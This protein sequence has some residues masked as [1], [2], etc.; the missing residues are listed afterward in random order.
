MDLRCPQ[1]GSP[2]SPD[3]YFCPNCGKKIK[4]PPPSTSFK[5]QLGVYFVSLFIPP[6]GLWYAYKYLRRGGNTENKIGYA[7]II[8]TIIGIWLAV[9]MAQSLINSLNQALSVLNNPVNF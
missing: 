4:N 7:A 1:C 3:V 5:A 6:F 8:L 2:V 9:W